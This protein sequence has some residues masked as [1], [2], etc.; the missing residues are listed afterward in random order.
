MK[1][2]L[3]QSSNMQVVKLAE[4]LE[5]REPAVGQVRAIEDGARDEAVGQVGAREVGR[6]QVGALPARLL[7]PHAA[8]RGRRPRGPRIGSASQSTPADRQPLRG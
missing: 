3:G 6:G 5:P 7:S 8:Q 2:D 4:L 1:L